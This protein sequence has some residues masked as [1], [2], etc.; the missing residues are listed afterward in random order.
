MA[1]V[2]KL[3]NRFWWVSW[4]L[5]ATV[6][7]VSS[8]QTL[9]SCGDHTLQLESVYTPSTREILFKVKK[10]SGKRKQLPSIEN[11]SMYDQIIF[12]TFKFCDRTVQW[13]VA[14]N[15]Q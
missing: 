6:T 5:P 11:V 4:T 7:M 2:T 10:M 9:F 13:F 1:T 14:A 12:R 15:D 3:G 8:G